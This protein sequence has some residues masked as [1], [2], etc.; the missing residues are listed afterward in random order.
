MAMK[1]LGS[2]RFLARLAGAL[3]LVLPLLAA[4]DEASVRKLVE[5]QHKGAK[6][7]SIVKTPYGGLYEVFMDNRI[8]YVDEQVSFMFAGGALIDTKTNANVTELSFRKRT[9]LNLKDLPPL[10]MAIKR[11]RGNGKRTLMV[12]TDPMCPFCKGLEKELE[13]VNNVSIYV[14]MYPIESKFPGTTVLSNSMWCSSDRA[15]A[16]DDWM[17]RNVTPTASSKACKKPVAELEKIGGRLGITVTPTLIFADGAPIAG[18]I[19]AQ[20][21]DRYL[22]QTPAK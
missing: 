7:E 21:I 20:D 11:V 10:S 4:A 6:I 13:K 1:T 8:F 14:F 18:A 9:A 5:L 17:L 19:R 15:K 16:W 22:D 12:F 3:C 2:V